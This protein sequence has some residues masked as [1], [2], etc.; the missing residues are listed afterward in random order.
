MQFEIDIKVN[1]KAFFN[2]TYYQE[3]EENLTH[4][5]KQGRKS[6]Y[7]RLCKDNCFSF[8]DGFWMVVVLS[9]NLIK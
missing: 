3:R 9:P 4:T 5:P 7:N 6:D 1:R 8:F 2:Y